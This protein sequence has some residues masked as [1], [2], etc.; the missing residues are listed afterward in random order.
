[1]IRVCTNFTFELPKRTAIFAHSKKTLLS[2][3][4]L[5]LRVSCLQIKIMWTRFRGEYLQAWHILSADYSPETSSQ[6]FSSGTPS[7]LE[8]ELFTVEPV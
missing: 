3:I 8:R 1:M 6:A 5:N 4:S 2:S 7:V